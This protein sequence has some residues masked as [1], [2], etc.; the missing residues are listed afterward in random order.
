MK[1]E[2]KFFLNRADNF[3]LDITSDTSK[4]FTLVG[5]QRYK[6]FLKNI[7]GGKA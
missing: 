5:F 7:T 2:K 1:A 6:R 4:T 3:F